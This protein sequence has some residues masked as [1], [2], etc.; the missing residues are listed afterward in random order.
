VRHSP[1]HLQTGH[2]GE[3]EYAEFAARTTH[4]VVSRTLHTVSWKNS[5]IVRDL[6]EVRRLR[7]VPGAICMP[8]VERLWYRV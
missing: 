1:I 6:E 2:S 5:R 7:E 3:V 4:F 8:L